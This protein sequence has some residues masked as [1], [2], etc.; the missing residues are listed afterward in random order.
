MRHVTHFAVCCSVLQ[1]TCS[2]CCS[3]RGSVLHQCAAVGVRQRAAVRY[4]ALQF[5]M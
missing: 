3:T 5:D 4:S 1:H 2:M